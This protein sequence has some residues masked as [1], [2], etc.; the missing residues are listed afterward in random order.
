MLFENRITYV[1]E[2]VRTE[3]SHA[4]EEARR[5]ER[6]RLRIDDTHLVQFPYADEYAGQNLLIKVDRASYHPLEQA[7]IY[8]NIT[9]ISD[10]P[11]EAHLQF[12]FR[13]ETGEVTK[14]ERWEHNI[15]FH[16]SQVKYGTVGYF[17]S[18]GWNDA[19][20]SPESTTTPNS[21][22]LCADTGEVRQCDSLNEDKTNC[23]SLNNHV[24]VS[25]E[26]SYREGW[27]EQT[28]A[29][30]SYTEDQGM[31]S[32]LI[33]KFLSDVPEHAIPDAVIP[34]QYSKEVISLE[35]GQT[36]YL[37]IQLT[38]PFNSKGQMFIEAA[39]ESGMFGLKHIDWNASWNAKK[40]I[41][42]DTE[43][44]TGE[45]LTFPISLDHAGEDFWKGVAT[46]GAD[47][48]FVDS[49]T[50]HELP[51]S[52]LEWDYENK[53]ATAWVDFPRY[54]RATSTI[55]LYYGD[56]EATHENDLALP[57]RSENPTA[58]YVVF[59]D[60][61]QNDQTLLLVALD[62]HVHVIVGARDQV[63]MMKGEQLVVGDIVNG[64]TVYADGAI[65]GVVHSVDGDIG[66]FIDT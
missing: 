29:P 4:D 33:Q 39:G 57:M 44:V 36:V 38:T 54:R 50:S 18:V 27:S 28:L 61:S 3:L 20:S 37:R 65:T 40:D 15:P 2:N 43:N 22:F 34:G 47:I 12:H 24:G 17:C 52:M 32:Q 42:I 59:G 10:A 63:T 64:E 46:S 16:E 66:V 51:F 7:V 8:A 25:E 9:N 55:S 31:L 23:L 49:E 5:I 30:G 26:I 58:R 48:R 13:N 14:V 11:E 35:P 60:S 45:H 56:H 19:T 21:G 41:Q 1:Q 6:D 62:D 53:H